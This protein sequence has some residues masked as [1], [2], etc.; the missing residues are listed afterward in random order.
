ML[1][2]FIA[3][4]VFRL[5]LACYSVW[6]K[7]GL[8]HVILIFLLCYCE[9]CVNTNRRNRLFTHRWWRLF[10]IYNVFRLFHSIACYV[11]GFDEESRMLRRSLM[12]YMNLA[13]ILVLRYSDLLLKHSVCV[14]WSD[15]S[16]SVNYKLI[17]CSWFYI[18]GSW[19]VHS[20]NGDY[21]SI[22]VHTGSWGYLFYEIPCT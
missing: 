19:S 16:L 4:Y 9:F 11:E 15:A 1:Y 20:L 21:L 6:Y 10:Y 8:F 7:N 17:W 2:C 5:F 3:C 12:R 22:P 13:L 18:K 14:S